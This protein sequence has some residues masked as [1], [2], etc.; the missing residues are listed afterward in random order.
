V[1]AGVIWITGLSGA[2]K[3]TVAHEVKRRLRR[4][5]RPAI[6]LDGD[7]LRAAIDDPAIGHDLA[8]RRAN[9]YRI[10]A[11][12]RMLAEQDLDVVVATM[13]L[14]HEV[15]VWNRRHLNGYFEVFLD[16]SEQTRM[17]RDPKGIYAR[18]AAGTEKNVAGWDIP[19]E[20][21]L[22]P[23]RRVYND[24]GSS[25]VAAIA[26]GIVDGYLAH[27]RHAAPGSGDAAQEHGVS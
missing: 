19:A 3:T 1:T 12:A 15:H 8:G 14:F 24:G 22:R 25:S 10:A 18:A 23:H 26:E 21:P 13:S 7:T 4:L 6:V 11:V 2:G 17:R 16:A 20:L 5:G 27:R 9:A